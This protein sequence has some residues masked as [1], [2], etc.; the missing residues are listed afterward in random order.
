M[1]KNHGIDPVI[2]KP[3]CD[4]V[5]PEKIGME[6]AVRFLSLRK[7]LDVEMRLREGTSILGEKESLA[8]FEKHPYIVASDTIVYFDHII[9]KP[10]DRQDAEKMLRQLEGKTHFVV[11]GVAIVQAGMPARRCFAEASRVTFK[12]YDEADFQRYLDTDEPYDKAGGYAIQG[13][14]SGYIEGVTGDYDNIVGFPW[15]RFEN[16]FEILFKS[17]YKK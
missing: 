1:M 4:E 9:G 12:S 10:K 11:S 5:L 6:D 3:L 7:A 13:H 15:E 17:S 16:E 14:F 8:L 2:I